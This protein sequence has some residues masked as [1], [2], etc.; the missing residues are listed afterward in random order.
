[1]ASQ[2]TPCQLPSVTQ[3]L[4]AEF[5]ECTTEHGKVPEEVFPAS[6]KF[7]SQIEISKDGKENLKAGPSEFKPA[8]KYVDKGWRPAHASTSGGEQHS[9]DLLQMASQ[10]APFQLSCAT[11]SLRAEF[12]ECTTEQGKVTDEVS[13]ASHK[14]CS[15]ID[16][17]EDGQENLNASLSDKTAA[18]DVGKSSGTEGLGNKVVRPLSRPKRCCL[19]KHRHPSW[20]HKVGE[21]S[22]NHRLFLS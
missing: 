15:Q 14:F 1:M 12:T 7:Q 9:E 18:K 13:V 6:H 16:I 2:V 19:K 22:H 10:V 17:S 4:H 20:N 11:Q 5:T 3:S 8:A 21:N